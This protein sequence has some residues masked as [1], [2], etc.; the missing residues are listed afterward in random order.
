MQIIFHAWSQP[1]SRLK[2]GFFYGWIIVLVVFITNL[3]DGG[4][5][6]YGMSFFIVPM[7]EDLGMSRAQFSGVFIFDLLLMPLAPFMGHLVDKKHGPRI[8]LTV[9]SVGVGLSMMVLGTSQNVVHFYLFFGLLFSAFTLIGPVSGAVVPKWFIRLRGRAMAMAIMG[10]SA[11]GFIVAPLA[12]WLIN[13]FGW[14]VAWLAL[15]GLF[16]VAIAP[17]AAI[18]MRRRPEDMGLLPDGDTPRPSSDVSP[19]SGAIWVDAEYPWTPREAFRTRAFWLLL[20][21]QAMGG[22]AVGPVL[23]HQVAYMRD[24]G[25][26][27]LEA[28]GVATALAVFAMLAKPLWGFLAE[29]IHVRWLVPMALIPAG[30]TLSLLTYGQSLAMLYAYAALHGL[31]MGAWALLTNLSWPTYFGRQRIGSIIGWAMVPLSVLGFGSGVF[32]GW[33]W[34]TVGNYNIAFKVYSVVF[35]LAGLLMLINWPPIPPQKQVDS[36][37]DDV[38]PTP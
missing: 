38:V 2:K 21:M 33:T 13:E 30:L 7:T 12:G 11:G 35:V 14:R 3:I 9:G 6:V 18:F 19:S 32:G 8:M 10:I 17:P 20:G 5:T 16:I 15:G 37:P 34:D 36:V 22:M 4:I 24:K 31:T 26:S 25:F 28:T 27:N 29:R 1:P 23:L